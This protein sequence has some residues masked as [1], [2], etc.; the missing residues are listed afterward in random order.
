MVQIYKNL[1]YTEKVMKK[2]ILVGIVGT[3]FTLLLSACSHGSSEGTSSTS[4]TSGNG[5]VATVTTLSSGNTPTTSAQNITPIP[6]P[7]PLENLPRE[8]A[9]KARYIIKAKPNKMD[10]KGRVIISYFSIYDE[11]NG[12]R[13]F[14]D[15]Y[16]IKKEGGTPR[17]PTVH[18]ETLT[19][20]VLQTATEDGT[21]YIPGNPGDPWAQ[22]ILS[23]R[24]NKDK[25]GIRESTNYVKAWVETTKFEKLWVPY[26]YHVI[27]DVSD[28][29]VT[30]W[31]GASDEPKEVFS[32]TLSIVGK[33]ANPTPSLGLTY[34]EAKLPNLELLNDEG[35]GTGETP[36]GPAYGSRIFALAAF[37][38][39]LEQFNEGVPQLAIH[40]TNVPQ[41]VGEAL[42]SGCIRIP[43]EVIDELSKVLMV[44][45]PVTI[46]A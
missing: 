4:T 31:K 45:T 25:T 40:G 32:H 8:A 19:F 3:A 34:I 16:V 29:T 44:G 39:T 9:L 26:Q 15:D 35:E 41:R 46:I 2:L 42:S 30:V 7:P 20:L 1:K 13:L 6:T 33:P 38:E 18:N 24:P 14:L 28:R 5:P 10:S 11:P 12:N 37:S 23:A 17:S 36:Y 22:V 27:V 43:N 21:K